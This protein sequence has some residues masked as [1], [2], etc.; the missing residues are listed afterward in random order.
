MRMN[1]LG[2]L[3][4]VLFMSAFAASASAEEVKIIIMQDRA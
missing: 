2:V 3:V 1:K 4:L